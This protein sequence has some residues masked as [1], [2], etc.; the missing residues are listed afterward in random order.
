M[1]ELTVYSLG[2]KDDHAVE[3]PEESSAL[4]HSRVFVDGREIEWASGVTVEAQGGDFTQASV[5]VNPGSV[6]FV[7]C[8]RDEWAQNDVAAAVAA[9][10]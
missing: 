8:T 1:N 6:K 3:A 5:H 2:W 4:L 9:R 7:T 10:P